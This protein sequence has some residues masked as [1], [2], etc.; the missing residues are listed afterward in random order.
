[1][2]FI[3]HLFTGFV[4]IH[5]DRRFADDHAIRRPPKRRRRHVTDGQRT[6]HSNHQSTQHRAGNIA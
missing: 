2:D 1:M 5:G 6:N 4:E 3:R